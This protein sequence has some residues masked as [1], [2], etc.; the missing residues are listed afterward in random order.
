MVGKNY[1]TIKEIVFETIHKTQGKVVY[2]KLEEKVLR[3]FPK[4]AF[5]KTHW[6]WY[7]YQCTKGKY[8]KYFSKLEKQNLSATLQSQSINKSNSKH[9]KNTASLSN[10]T[11]VP[12]TQ[13]TMLKI[14]SLIK[15]AIAYENSIGGIRKAGITAEVG[16]I[17]ACYHLKL[18]LCADSKAKGFD[19]IERKRRRVQ[20][21]TRRSETEGLPSDAGRLSSFSKHPF[22]Y[23][24]LVLLDHNY[25]LAE[26]WRAEYGDTLP[27]IEKQKRRNPNLSSFKIVAKQI[28]PKK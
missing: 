28:W 18:R 4:S 2:K 24:I 9:P 12:I 26:M 21:K 13:D 11:T 25:H 19:A 23:V 27:L 20:I 7:R 3:H 15:S 22:D 14:K 6:T 17:L 1:S 8:S 16:E 10:F 5:K